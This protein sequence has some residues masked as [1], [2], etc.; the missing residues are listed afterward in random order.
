MTNRYFMSFEKIKL[1]T[2]RNSHM[3]LGR[4]KWKLFNIKWVRRCACMCL[5]GRCM[6]LTHFLLLRSVSKQSN[7]DGHCICTGPTLML[8][9]ILCRAFPS[10]MITKNLTNKQILFIFISAYKGNILQNKTTK[11]GLTL[12][13]HQHLF[14]QLHPSQYTSCSTTLNIEH[15]LINDPE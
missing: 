15:S 8:V 1:M 10:N 11:I 3:F 7:P 12:L 9:Q 6:R 5:Y 13:T 4:E 14:N 2:W